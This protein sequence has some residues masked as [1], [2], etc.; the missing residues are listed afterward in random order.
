MKH[1]TW[2]RPECLYSTEALEI[3]REFEALS[4]YICPY[5]ERFW[6]VLFC[7]PVKHWAHPEAG[8]WL[9]Y[10]NALAGTYSFYF[11]SKN[12]LETI[13]SFAN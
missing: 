8:I 12:N 3:S 2:E 7:L 4:M 6:G 13:G 11:Q 9:E 10:N 5:L 1:F